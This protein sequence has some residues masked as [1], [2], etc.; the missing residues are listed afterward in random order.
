MKKIKLSTLHEVNVYDSKDYIENNKEVN[1]SFVN[2]LSSYEYDNADYDINKARD[3][4][5][6][7]NYNMFLENLDS[8]IYVLQRE[9]QPVSFALY[10]RIQKTNDWVL[11]LIYT[12]SEHTTCGFATAL[13]RLSAKDLKERFNAENI[14]TTVSHNNYKSM[15]L[16]SSFSKV[17]GVKVA[18]DKESTK[19][20]FR[21]NIKNMSY[22]KDKNEEAEMLF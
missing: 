5:E 18:L 10:N 8:K 4:I 15:Y 21:F 19:S 14:H 20:R 16:H 6:N 13:L 12:H 11:E 9:D 22:G 7:L 3:Y 17:E 1:D 2:I